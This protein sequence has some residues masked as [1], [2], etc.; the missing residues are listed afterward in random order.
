MKNRIITLSIRQIIKTYKRF[1][2]LAILS[3]LGV[4][5]FV[6]IKMASPD[7][8]ASLDKYYDTKNMYDIKV[9][10]TL[11]LTNKDVETIQ[12]LNENFKV[13]GLHSKDVEIKTQESNAVI[14]LMEINDNINKIQITDGRMPEN[15]NE[16]LVEDFMIYKAKLKIGDTIKLENF[17][18]D[19]TLNNKEFTIVGTVRSPVYIIN[20]S[21]NLNRG[22]T[23]LGNGSVNFYAYALDKT[24]NMD[25]F[26][27][28]YLMVNNNYLT[29]TEEYNNLIEDA[30]EQIG[31]IQAEREKARKD[32]LLNEANTKINEEEASYLE[33]FNEAKQKLDEAETEIKKGQNLI[34]ST[35]NELKNAKQQLDEKQEE[36]NNAY[37]QL[38]DAKNQLE[39]GKT[40]LDEG[41]EEINN[42]ISKY[43]LQYENIVTIKEAIER[44]DITKA[45]FKSIVPQ[46]IKYYD[47]IIKIIDYVYDN[48]YYTEF[49]N[50]LDNIDTQKLINSIQEFIDNNADTVESLN[51]LK[52][53]V[54]NVKQLFNGVDEIENGLVTYNESAAM[55]NENEAKL[56][57]GYNEFIKY[58]NEYQKGL[59]ELNKGKNE[60]YNGL[61]LYNTNLAEYNAKLNE[62]EENIK[63]AREDVNTIPK[64]DWYIFTR[65]DS[66][67]YNSFIESSES[68]DN[69][70]VIFPT[71]FF[72]VSIFI[73]LL[74]MSRMAI[75]DRAEIGTLKSLGYNNMSIR[76]KYIIYSLLA[77]ILGGILG[78]LCGLVFLPNVIFNTYKIMYE[79]PIFEYSKDIMPAIIGMILS[80][81][82]ICGATIIT[83]NGLIKEKTTELLRPKAPLKGKKI[84]LEK[85]TFIWKRIKFSNKVTIRN[86]LRY[87]KRVGMTMLGIVGC[88]TLLLSGYAIKDSIVNIADK[89]FSEVFNYD[90]IILL[91]GKQSKEELNE[92]FNNNYI[93]SRLDTK[94]L[95]VSLKAKSANLIVPE[96]TSKI[97]E[98]IKLND[99]ET[100]E[101]VY[102][103]K[104][105]V[106]ITSKLA[107]SLNLK[108]NDYIEFQ[109][110]DNNTYKFK[111]SGI[112][113]NY[114]GHYIYMD[115]ETFENN[116]D[117]IDINASFIKLNNVANEDN[118]LK[119]LLKNKHVLTFSSA[120]EN[121]E[122]VSK[123]FLSLDKIVLILV[124]FS[125]ALSFVV[126]YNLSY[127]NI[128][129]RQ[130]E[131]A[132]L[133]VLGFN[134][135]EID[136]YIIKEEVIITVA[137]ILLG[138]L[139]GTWF[140]MTIVETI[141][142]EVVEFIKNITPMSYLVTTSFMT[143][144][145]VIVNIKV[146][147]TLKKINMIES[148]KS[149]E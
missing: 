145:A 93:K 56:N 133:K 103:E 29:N 32:E 57:E 100:K 148:L 106:I 116:I 129:E 74:S 71:I 68:V 67:D 6:G 49:K 85:V 37:T 26:T 146:H 38:E 80:I 36:I 82:C 94:M 4:S 123:M 119:E 149:I 114:V 43:G 22:N 81:T 31:Q 66:N 140:G 105:S 113:Q 137:G 53:Y 35:E 92:I 47:N 21:G 41:I 5:V 45:E 23:T 136:A 44:K 13:Y 84:I 143:I 138:L 115:K 121:I 46:T 64:A 117:E 144:F 89:H 50:Y 109:D 76:S 75:E 27:E 96:D 147:F 77:T 7:M 62:F 72:A 54:N 8:M 2:S 16:I 142:L 139:A 17:E 3:F 87:K 132:T 134:H 48:N 91:D 25:Y 20:G 120:S 118:V 88:T 40:K 79:V 42:K 126:L 63:K 111:I 125:G 39:Q 112:V 83:I 98:I 12:S 101:K 128:S 61:S 141:E 107:K 95:T 59:Q 24:F 1:L 18:D 65:K 73:S 124:I 10:S 131:I 135:K 104:G 86:I 34:F 70:S 58:Q 97:D 55:L 127:I 60:Y 11:G 15:S 110:A 99:K 19:E 69:L 14:R 102:I 28:I 108:E 9:I 130:R 30:K 90:D 78:E 52:T 122:R 51:T 33:Q